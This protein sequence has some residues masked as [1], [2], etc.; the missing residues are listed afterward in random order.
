MIGSTLP[1][2]PS[3]AWSA[4]RTRD[5]PSDFGRQFGLETPPPVHPRPSGKIGP[6]DG[7]R[8]SSDGGAGVVEQ[9]T[10]LFELPA[11]PT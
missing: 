3:R 2:P 8:S 5:G 10:H 4:V 9:G 11:Q 1:V 7:A 6:R